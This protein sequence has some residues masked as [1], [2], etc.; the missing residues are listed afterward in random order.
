[1]CVHDD[2]NDDESWKPFVSNI[3]EKRGMRANDRE[4]SYKFI[5]PRIVFFVS[6]PEQIL[7]TRNRKMYLHFNT[8]TLA[9]HRLLVV[10]VCVC[11]SM[12]FIYK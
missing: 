9:L 2:D 10:N 6:F 3:I 8:S 12:E 7:I 1:M 11:L 4:K 5:M